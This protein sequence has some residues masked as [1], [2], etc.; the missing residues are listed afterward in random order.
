VKALT[1]PRKKHLP[2]STQRSGI[3]NPPDRFGIGSQQS[4]T[5]IVVGLPL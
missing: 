4:R 1:M 5:M 3:I 2:V